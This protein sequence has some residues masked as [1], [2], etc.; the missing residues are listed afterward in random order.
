MMFG[1]RAVEL[2]GMASLVL[3]WRPAEFWSST[4]VELEMALGHG[5]EAAGQI[6]RDAFERLRAQFPDD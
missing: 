3:G 2:A 1:E 4:P 6:D 5:P